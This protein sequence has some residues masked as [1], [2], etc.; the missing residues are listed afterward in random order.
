MS[1]GF[2]KLTD[3]L[4]RRGE[5]TALDIDQ[6]MLRIVHVTMSRGISR[7]RRIELIP[8]PNEELDLKDPIATGK[9]IGKQLKVI[10]LNPGVVVMAAR[11][12]E[13]ILKE[14][15]LP[16]LKDIGEMASMVRVKASRDLPFPESKASIDFTVTRVP[17]K[18]E[19]KESKNISSSSNT[20]VDP[21]ANVVVSA[22]KNETLIF[23]QTIVE[24]AG[25]TL[26]GLGLRPMASFRVLK[27][28]VPSIIKEAVA[29]IS[30]RRH[31]VDVDILIDGRLIFS[32]ELSANLNLADDDKEPDKQIDLI[33]I[34]KEIFRCLHSY[35]GSGAYQ[36]L[37]HLLVAGGTGIENKL[38]HCL[39]SQSEVEWKT[40]PLP[41]GLRLPKDN[42]NN[43]ARALTSLGLALGFADEGGMP[44][45]F[46]TPKR[47]IIN[48]NEG[49]MKWILGMSL[50]I[51]GAL[52]LF[53]IQKRLKSN[54]QTELN[55]LSPQYL[56]L[57]KEERKN[58][59]IIRTGDAVTAWNKDSKDWLGH[60]AFISAILPPCDKIYLKNLGTRRVGSNG[61]ISFQLQAKDSTTLHSVEKRLRDIGYEF[62]SV[63]QTPGSDRHGYSFSASFEL[64][65]PNNFKHNLK[66]YLKT[67]SPP[68]RIKDD[69]HADGLSWI[70]QEKKG[71]TWLSLL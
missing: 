7:V 41:S 45:N 18:K 33:H 64:I 37:D 4:K 39:N 55:K 48:R 20:T 9:W 15:Q 38:C 46:L 2:K 5:V 21:K 22:I 17:T 36:K 11:R 31:E 52:M 12:G 65:I 35:E 51:A 53:S 70:N 10:R 24:S 29:L 32:R 25:F 23:Y 68:A 34:T 62:K 63:P 27:T 60:F 8:L 3:R 6:R 14:Y 58:K 71:S 56:A 13:C 42:K 26:A 59:I 69:I 44:V 16:P 49:R 61:V 19:I 66:D 67:N 30:I 40:M 28:C 50:I 1:K 43:T 57:K 54:A 47:P